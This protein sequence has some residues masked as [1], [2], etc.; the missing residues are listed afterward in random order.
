MFGITHV[1]RTYLQQY[2]YSSEKTLVVFSNVNIIN[3]IIY[4]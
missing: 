2:I 3:N 4:I 1:P